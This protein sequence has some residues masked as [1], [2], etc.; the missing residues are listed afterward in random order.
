MSTFSGVA[1]TNIQ[2]TISTR[3]SA[4][5]NP[6]AGDSTIAATVLPKPAHCT[7]P[8]PALQTPAPTS[9]PI[10]AWLEDEGMPASQVTMFQT[11]APISAP[12]IT[13]SEMAP[14]LMMPVPMV[15]ATC[16][17]N[18]AKAIKL[19]NAAQATA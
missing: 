12:K 14:G 1:R 4:S 15:E 10:R 3:I 19:K 13:W 7:T 9:P 11:I 16:N 2:D 17:P 8:Q 5:T 6:L 18:T